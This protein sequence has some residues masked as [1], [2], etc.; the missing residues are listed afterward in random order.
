[1]PSL[2]ATPTFRH[3]LSS[4]PRPSAYTT[5]HSLPRP[6]PAMPLP[7][8]TPFH[9]HAHTSPRPPHL[10]HALPLPLPVLG[11]P[12]HRIRPSRE[13]P[14]AIPHPGA[15]IHKRRR[16]GP[17]AD[18]AAALWLSW[19]LHRR[20]LSKPDLSSVIAGD[21][22][23]QPCTD[24]PVTDGAPLQ[25]FSPRPGCR[26]LG[27]ILSLPGSQMQPPSLGSAEAGEGSSFERSF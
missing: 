13:S 12:L 1:M 8:V 24:P 7:P 18:A 3:A 26:T 16:K 19:E 27:S 20:L 25:S 10:S 9:G 14:P 15:P 4:L 11:A 6:H 22:F 5:P 2:F 23:H 17:G 21:L